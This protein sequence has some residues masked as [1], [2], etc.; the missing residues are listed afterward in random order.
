MMTSVSWSR[1]ADRQ[2]QPPP[3]TTSG[4]GQSSS[5]PTGG[6]EP[7][8]LLSREGGHRGWA[9]P[10]GQAGSRR[11]EVGASSFSP[12]VPPACHKQRARAVSS[13]QPRSLHMDR[14]HG[15]TA[16]DL[17]WERRPKLHGM[18]GVEFKG[19]F[20]S[21][22]RPQGTGAPRCRARTGR[23]HLSCEL[24]HRLVRQTRS[25][26]GGGQGV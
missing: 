5:L 25:Y 26:Y 9:S 16:P 18:Q 20:D 7:F 2:P 3:G 8:G 11:R 6:R 15:Q 19:I 13:G 10:Y 17:G 22:R 14:R 4:H 24:R 1:R 21:G 23:Q 12:V